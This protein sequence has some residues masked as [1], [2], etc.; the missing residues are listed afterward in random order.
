MPT[1]KK[2]THP[3]LRQPIQAVLVNDHPARLPN[4]CE[5]TFLHPALFD[6]VLKDFGWWNLHLLVCVHVRADTCACV[7]RQQIAQWRGSKT[8]RTKRFRTHNKE[9]SKYTRD[10]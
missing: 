10:T 3:F 2:D 7:L 8:Q 6:G 4:R 9:T 1:K 5:L